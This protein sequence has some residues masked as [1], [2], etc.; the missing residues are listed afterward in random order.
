MIFR[1]NLKA[2]GWCLFWYDESF[3]QLLV[4]KKENEE[5]KE[6]LN[7]S[8]CNEGRRC[9]GSMWYSQETGV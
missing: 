3:V 6:K 5:I 7:R 4:Q 9:A 1:A 8:A 2:S